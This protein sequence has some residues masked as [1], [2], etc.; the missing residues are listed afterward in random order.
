MR[1]ALLGLIL[2]TACYAP[3]VQS[4]VACSENTGACPAG[5]S[6]V[7]GFCVYPEDPGGDAGFPDAPP[8]TVDTDKDGVPDNVDNCKTVANNDQLDED[9]D[10]IGDACDLCPQVSDTGADTDGDHIGDACDPNSGVH[11]TVWL[12]NGFAAGLPAWS[13]SDHWTAAAGNV[14]TTSPGNTTMD[15]EYLVTQ[16]TTSAPLDNF[17]AT[18]TVQ[19]TQEMGSKGDHSVGI[20]IWDN[21]SN[22]Q[23]GVDCGLDQGNGGT[24]SV[25]YLSDDF[26]NL[27]KSADY[28]W[29]PGDQYR[30][31]IAKHAKT[32]TCIVVGPQGTTTLMG[33][34]NV[35]PRDGNTV[36][37]WAYGATAQYG[38]I[39]IAGKQ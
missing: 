38:S 3:R 7:N 34:S 32:Y 4:G 36:D 25:V 31:T 9:G 14:V 5:Q 6:C 1:T 15:G 26:N 29:K 37:V 8:G 27:N 28:P 21:A 2:I 19:V 20:E 11:D 30:M 17:S 16:F 35:V 39:Q 23:K 13:R 22:V 12:W 33:D 24:N 10:K 18:M